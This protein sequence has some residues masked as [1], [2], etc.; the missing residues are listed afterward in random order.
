[1]W[2]GSKRH[3]Q[4]TAMRPTCKWKCPT[5]LRSCRA[6]A[7]PRTQRASI[8]GLSLILWLALTMSAPA[9]TAGSLQPH[10]VRT[11]SHLN[12]QTEQSPGAAPVEDGRWRHSRG[13]ASSRAEASRQPDAFD[14]ALADLERAIRRDPKNADHFLARGILYLKLREPDRAIRDFDQ[15][16]AINPRNAAALKHR[17]RAQ[18]Q[19]HHDRAIALHAA[20]QY[21]RAIRDLDR[22]IN[23]SPDHASSFNLRGMC[24]AAIGE[25]RRAIQD[26]DQAVQL[27]GNL[28]EAFVN[29][30][31]IF[32]SANKWER[33]LADY[34]EAA[35]LKPQD[36]YSLYS[37][38]LVMRALG[39]E[40][41]A[42]VDLARAKEI[43]PGIGP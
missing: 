3:S 30:G 41:E 4:G 8:P 6:V 39:R 29:R 25:T 34:S 37:R 20:R 13:L 33:A 28:A 16:V 17:A 18:T 9:Q 7:G 1:M 36:A 2:K 32:Q 5:Q 11:L 22:A 21:D 14:D 12:G 10:S 26:F 19:A 23:F 15:A 24:Y 43:E 31:N 35:R 42:A 27:D 40:S 38:G